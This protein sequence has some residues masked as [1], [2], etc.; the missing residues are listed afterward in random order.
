MRHAD[1]KEQR[2]E[3]EHHAL[4][5]AE[6]LSLN[7]RSASGILVAEVNAAHMRV[8]RDPPVLTDRRAFTGPDVR[9]LQEIASRG[10]HAPGDAPIVSEEHLDGVAPRSRHEAREN[11]WPME[12]AVSKRSKRDMRVREVDDSRAAGDGGYDET[13]MA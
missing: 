11:T 7:Q 2:H 1:R 4:H 9:W 6:C 8:L 5:G 10:R 13:C 12:K 3:Y